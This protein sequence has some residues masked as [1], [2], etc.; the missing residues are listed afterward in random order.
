M[1]T[2]FANATRAKLRFTSVRGNLSVEDLWDLPLTSA[3][4]ASLDEVG[5]KLLAERK[6]FEEESLVST[7]PNPAKAINADA[8]EIVKYIVGVKEAER[9]AAKAAKEKAAL[10]AQLTDV[11][12]RKQAASM[13]ELTEQQIIDKINAL[14]A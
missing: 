10:K 3:K 1:S 13:E 8:I 9:D 14:G 2:I 6:S 12:A 11:L 4:G 7:K 5:R